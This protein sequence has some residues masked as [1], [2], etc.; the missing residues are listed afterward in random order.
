MRRRNSAELF[1]CSGAL[2]DPDAPQFISC[3]PFVQADRRNILT[4]AEGSKPE[5]ACVAVMGTSRELSRPRAFPLANMRRQTHQ[6]AYP[7]YLGNACV[8][9]RGTFHRVSTKSIS[10]IPLSVEPA[11]VVNATSGK[12]TSR[13]R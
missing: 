9:L 4:R 10:P 7:F 6:A 5:L 3:P 13:R 12:L 8:I 2:T 1:L 11:H